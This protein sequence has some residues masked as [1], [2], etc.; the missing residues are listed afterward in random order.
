MTITKAL[1]LAAGDGKRMRPLTDTRNKSL[2]PVANKPLI[3]RSLAAL[4]AVGISQAVIVTDK[5]RSAEVF[6]GIEHE[7]VSLSFVVQE[8]PLGTAHAI[9][10]A[11][12]KISE[13]FLVLNGD[14]L[15]TPAHLRQVISAHN[16]KATVSVIKMENPKGLGVVEIADSLVKGIIEKPLSAEGER[17]VN[18][19]IYAF[20]PEIFSTIETLEKSTRGEYEITDAIQKI[21]ASGEK[22]QA[23]EADSWLPIN[24]PWE[25]LSASKKFI[26][27]APEKN[28]AI[29][30]EY[31]KVKGKLIAGEGTLIKSGVYIEGPVIIGKNCTIGP[32]AFLRPYTCI[33]DNCKVGQAVE[34]KNSTIMSGTYVP[35]LSYVGDSVI[36]R[37]VNFGAGA[38][39]ANLRHDDRNILVNVKDKPLDSGLR[40]LGALV[41]DNVKFGS[42]VVINP[43]KKVGAGALVW[44]GVVINN[45]I[46]SGTEYKG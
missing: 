27:E 35:H 32:N 10:M 5:A 7:G 43:G 34:I 42:N 15:C 19:G 33:G 21:I 41:G 1:I 16:S 8:E 22:V 28:K 36:G 39:T 3:S 46:E 26:D 2:L 30:E 17:F 38:I 14:D 9:S 23:V 6:L 45:D 25:L 4:K 12:Q 11:R 20:S 31:V 37:N 44:P 24:Y 18:I 29:V 40:K 13:D